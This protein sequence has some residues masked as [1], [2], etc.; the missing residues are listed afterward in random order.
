MSGPGELP[1]EAEARL[2]DNLFVV[3]LRAGFSLETLA[4]L[5]VVNAG[6]IGAMENGKT[7]A[8]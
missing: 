6:G 1:Y 2:A 3:R 8:D 4:K 7:S 5:A